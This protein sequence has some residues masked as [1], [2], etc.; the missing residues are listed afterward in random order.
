MRHATM[1]VAILA[2][3]PLASGCSS[4]A[5][6]RQEPLPEPGARVLVWHVID[7]DAG[8][9]PAPDE[10]NLIRLTAD[11]IVLTVGKSESQRAVPLTSVSSLKVWRHRSSVGQRAGLGTAVGLGLGALVGY[12]MGEDCPS[13][14]S[15]RDGICIGRE[16]TT[17]ILGM[18]GAIVGL[19]AGIV[20][21]V[22]D[23]G[24]EWEGVRLDPLRVSLGPQRDG[25]FGLGASVRF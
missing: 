9:R 3:V 19:L 21:G 23:N 12:T 13:S 8:T 11:S 7:H 10:G 24:G 2:F 20:V 25:R 14:S 5:A 4:R 22:A 6:V 15:W 17:L 16:T 18:G 1:L